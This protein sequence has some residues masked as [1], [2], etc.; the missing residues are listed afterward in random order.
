M[1]KELYDSN[2]AAKEILDRAE[3]VM[4]GLLALCFEGPEDQL[5]LTE[6]TQPCLLAIDVAAYAAFGKKPVA[7]AG[8]SLGE[9]AA[10][11]AAEALTLE[12]ALPLVRARA[13]AMQAAVPPGV[14]GMVVLRKMNEEQAREVAASVTKG[15]CDLANF[16]TPGQIVLSGAVEAMDEVVEKLGRKAMKLKVSVPFHSSLLKEA[17]SGFA[18]KLREVE[19]QV[20]KFPVYCNVDAAKVESADAVRDALER[21]FAG[22]VLWQQSVEAMFEHGH[23]DFIEF[24]PKPTLSRMVTQI[25][26]AH[27]VEVSARTVATPADLEA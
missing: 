24:G 25:A 5:V 26:A 22:S 3:A 16:N 18:A 14:G 19:F 1:G 12:A 9:Y 21:Q 13:E 6:N 27:S 15:V 23:R 2:S 7:A 8:H 11:V 17:G 10:L 20:P 4:P